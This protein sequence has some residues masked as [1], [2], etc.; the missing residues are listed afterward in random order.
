MRHFVLNFMKDTEDL[1]FTVEGF[2]F[3]TLPNY[4]NVHGIVR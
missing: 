4:N 3:F 1:Y 2:F